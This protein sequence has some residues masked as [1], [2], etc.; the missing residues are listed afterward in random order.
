MIKKLLVRYL[1]SAWIPFVVF[2]LVLWLM[3]LVRSYCFQPQLFYAD[4]EKYFY[5]R[6]ISHQLNN[7][8]IE[9]FFY[10]GIIIAGL[11]Q[12]QRRYFKR[13][14]ISLLIAGFL[15]MGDTYIQR[16]N[17]SRLRLPED[18]HEYIFASLQKV[19]Q[20]LALY[21]QQ[22]G[23]YPENLTDRCF[24]LLHI[25][26]EDFDYKTVDGGKDFQLKHRGYDF[27]LGTVDDVVWK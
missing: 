27:K 3:M 14:L 11:F 7:I 12:L 1:S 13:G 17:C 20:E 9:Q 8:P 10:W 15:L 23:I 22:Y 5:L 21:K 18:A 2:M 24:R 4:R 25:D 26:T 16:T 19:S 6:A